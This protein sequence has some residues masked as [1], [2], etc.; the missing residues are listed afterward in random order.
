ME[1]CN[2]CACSGGQ[3]ACTKKA[4]PPPACQDGAT[5]FD[6]CNTCTCG[7]GQWACTLRYCPPTDASVPRSCGG[8]AGN[9]CGPTEY[10]AYVVGQMCGAA[11]ASATCQPRPQACTLNYDPVCGCDGKTYGNTCAAGGAG[12]G[13]NHA[14]PC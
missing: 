13:V 8:F 9:T 4:C 14:G 3:W 5:T 12:T 6:G 1:S 11:D 2:T 10:C 7:G